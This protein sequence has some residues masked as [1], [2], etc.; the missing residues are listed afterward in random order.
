MAVP[1]LKLNLAP[2]P[3]LW[4][5]HHQLLGWAVLAAGSLGLAVSL[6]ASLVAYRDAIRA[7]R[8]AVLKTDEAKD[9][10]QK[11]LAI[12]NRLKAIDVEK[13][14]PVWRLA[15][16]ILGERSLPW[17]RLTAELERSL[18]QDVR[19]M[20]IQRIRNP[21]QTVELKIHGEA[22]SR[23]DE[24][25]FVASLHENTFFTQVDL[26]REAERQ[27]GG[28]EFEYT[29]T[30]SPT[31]PLYVPLSKYGPVWNVRTTP[32]APKSAPAI[33][34]PKPLSGPMPPPRT[35]APPSMFVPPPTVHATPLRSGNPGLAA[36]Q[37][38]EGHP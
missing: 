22:K 38:S 14:L 30:A 35:Q 28:V 12:Q 32:P 6:T 36:H 25:A 16:R 1:V 11:Q 9:V 34:L 3:S 18:V 8:N 5:Q 23:T 37:G 13:I 10:I 15:E 17:S 27:G 26:E 21:S 20:S 31:P 7:G 33:L 24:E 29:L 19:L 4:R 2:P